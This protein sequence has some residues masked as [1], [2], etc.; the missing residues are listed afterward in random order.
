[1][2]KV[3]NGKGNKSKKEK[4]KEDS[5]NLGKISSLLVRALVDKGKDG[6]L[7]SPSLCVRTFPAWA[8]VWTFFSFFLT[9]GFEQA[10]FEG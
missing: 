4:W 10:L 8:L 7:S 5:C 3:S 9:G 2:H 1:M 6:G